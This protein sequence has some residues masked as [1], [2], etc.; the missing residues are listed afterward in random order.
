M[1]TI[2]ITR[3]G[4]TLLP[5]PGSDKFDED[6][7]LSTCIGLH[8][9]CKGFVDAFPISESHNVLLCRHC[10]LRVP[11]PRTVETYKQLNEYCRRHLLMPSDWIRD[12]G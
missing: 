11:I 2:K 12:E 10:G 5:Y 4:E 6:G 9:V 8:A 1:R 7:K 3:L